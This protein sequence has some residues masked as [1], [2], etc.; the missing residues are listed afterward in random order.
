MSRVPAWMEDVCVGI[1]REV[2][3]QRLF[4]MC[5]VYC[6]AVLSLLLLL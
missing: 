6:Y 4:K 5:I 2:A 1:G 3:V